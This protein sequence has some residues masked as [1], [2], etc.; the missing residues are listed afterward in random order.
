MQSQ[1]EEGQSLF[2]MQGEELKLLFTYTQGADH[3]GL[4]LLADL[5]EDTYFMPCLLQVKTP[6]VVAQYQVSGEQTFAV[7]FPDSGPL[8]R[9]F[10]STV[11][12]LLS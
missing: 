7:Y 9:T 10:C 8:M 4:V 1:A 6:Q 5:S 3:T 12:Y 2:L 11:A